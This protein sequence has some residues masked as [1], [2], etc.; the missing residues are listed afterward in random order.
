MLG[1]LSARLSFN[2]IYSIIYEVLK[3]KLNMIM[4]NFP[5]REFVWDDEN[6]ELVPIEEYWV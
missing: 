4:I 2:D 6:K 5:Q 3:W 1:P